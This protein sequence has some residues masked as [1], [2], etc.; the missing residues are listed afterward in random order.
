MGDWWNSLRPG[1]M[2]NLVL[3][4]IDLANHSGWVAALEVYNKSRAAMARTELAV[5]LQKRLAFCGFDRVSW[6]GDGGA[7]ARV[8]TTREDA[9]SVCYAA[10]EALQSFY[11]WKEADWQI[12]LRI[13]A[14]LL[15]V[16]VIDRDPGYWMSQRMN[17]FLKK[18]REIILDTNRLYVT[19]ELHSVM[20]DR[21]PCFL[22]FEGPFDV[23]LKDATGTTQVLAVWRRL[24]VATGEASR[25]TSQTARPIARLHKSSSKSV[26]KPNSEPSRRRL[27][28]LPTWS[29]PQTPMDCP[30]PLLQP[31]SN[32]ALFGGRE[33]DTLSL[34]QHIA[35]SHL[36]TGVY[37]PS[38]A[39]KSSLLLAGLVPRL[40]QNRVPVVLDRH[41]E[42]PGIAFRLLADMFEEPDFRDCEDYDARTFSSWMLVARKLGGIR[43]VLILDQFENVFLDRVR[44]D[45]LARIGPLLAASA[46]RSPGERDPACRWILAYR[47]EVHGDVVEWLHDVLSDAYSFWGDRSQLESLP[48]DLSAEDRFR[49]WL[50]RPLGSATR[51]HVGEDTALAA[52]HDAIEKPLRLHGKDGAP[53][54]RWHFRMEDID[55]LARA[56]ARA[57]HE[58]PQTALVPEF[59]VVMRHLFDVADVGSDGF[60]QIHL[61]A[62]VEQMIDDAIAGHVRRTLESAFPS[63]PQARLR[64][65]RAL[66]ALMELADSQ[67]SSSRGTAEDQL[68]QALGEDGRTVLER[69]S[70]A[71]A[72][73]VV[74]DDRFGE[75]CWV[76]SHDQM[77][78]VVRRIFEDASLRHAYD[79]DERLIDLRRFVEGRTELYLKAH[80]TVSLELTEEQ[81]ELIGAVED[82]LL[83]HDDR[84]TWWAAA[85]AHRLTTMAGRLHKETL[86]GVISALRFLQSEDAL[87]LQHIRDA[88]IA[89][90]VRW[91]ARLFVEA[92]WHLPIEDRTQIITSLVRVALPILCEERMI[93]GAAWAALA[94]LVARDRT[95]GRLAK[96]AMDELW[97]Y[98]ANGA[99]IIP[100]CPSAKDD[101]EANLRIPVQSGVF[102]MGSLVGHDDERPVHEVYVSSFS[103][104]SHP[105]TN[106]EFERFKPGHEKEEDPRFPVRHVNWFEAM[107]YAAWLGGILPTEAQWEYAARGPSARPYPWGDAPPTSTHANYGGIELL[108]VGMHAN[109]RTP[110]G[111]EDFAGGVWEWCRDWLDL[112]SESQEDDPVGPFQGTQKVMRG[113]AWYCAPWSL[114]ATCRNDDNPLASNDYIGFRVVWPD[115]KAPL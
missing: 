95:H 79:L 83:L 68:I 111:I 52:F 4:H 37:A 67:R 45:A 106:A 20:S 112:Y 84:R 75:P 14:D 70:S 82:T 113:G 98:I 3:L 10:D 51:R 38:G 13:G 32:P 72:R 77:A 47:K 40:I 90:G 114:R 43:P 44:R 71:S 49:A 55:R 9:D 39:G 78:N 53:L 64:R 88:T 108:P 48:T 24:L 81:T 21:G 23:E 85:K 73:L 42:E 100:P 1:Q 29:E 33:S 101:K 93:L 7:F 94:D 60:I 87:T 62:N 107:A 74:Q 61:P 86:P 92:A 56:F 57:R 58:Q 109:G 97:R 19:N 25:P 50:L 63:G 15:H 6:A 115:P 59:Q 34:M 11:K 35:D 110:E 26:D 54:V 12:G 30:Y 2:C 31:Y 66:L 91:S 89:R 105:V 96:D 41:P 17:L 36:I 46:Q 99:G 65:T 104:Q 80:D 27:R 16:V 5:Q 8:F 103:I 18:E 69:L 76:L 102:T 28:Q 22:D